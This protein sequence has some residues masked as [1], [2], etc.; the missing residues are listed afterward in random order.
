MQSLQPVQYVSE[1]EQY[2]DGN[3][4]YLYLHIHIVIL[5][6]H[7]A[8]NFSCKQ[9]YILIE[10][11][12]TYYIC[13]WVLFTVNNIALPTPV[14]RK[15]QVRFLRQ[16]GK[17]IFSCNLH[18][19]V[20]RT[21]YRYTLIVLSSNANVHILRYFLQATTQ[22]LFTWPMPINTTYVL[23]ILLC[24]SLTRIHVCQNGNA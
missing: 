12:N 4:V 5:A 8:Y 19:N 20:R 13:A 1:L 9:Q 7:A 24:N 16:V 3:S 21:Y 17:Y 11:T 10:Y 18:K 23:Y 2:P 14:P 6:K 15:K 22:V